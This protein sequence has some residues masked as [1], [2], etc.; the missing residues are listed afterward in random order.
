MKKYEIMYI[1]SA[2]LDDAAKKNEIAKLQGILESIRPRSPMS[3]SGASRTSP[4]RSRNKP[5]VTTSCSK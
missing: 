1:L 5:K 4:T 3:R 2:D